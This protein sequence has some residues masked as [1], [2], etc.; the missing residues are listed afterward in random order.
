MARVPRGHFERSTRPVSSAIGSL[1]D[2]ALRGD[3]L[4]PRRR[5]KGQ[6]P[7]AERVSHLHADGELD[8][9]LDEGVDEGVAGPR[10][11]GAH[12]HGDPVFGIGAEGLDGQLGQ[13]EIEHR[14][15][16]RRAVRMGVARPQHH[17]EGLAGGVAKAGHRMEPKAVLVRRSG[18]VLLRVR[19]QEGG[20][21]VQDER[22][23]LAERAQAG[24]PGT[25][26]CLGSSGPDGSE[27][28]AV[29]RVDDPA[30]RRCRRHGTEERGLIPQHRK[31]R[32]A[33]A[34]V[35]QRERHVEEDSARIV[36]P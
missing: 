18:A 26:A 29:D 10:G 9:A 15:V 21:D 32:E 33:I 14:D 17:G 28:I 20:V 11:V 3:G 7:Q 34:T 6:D 25:S 5:G 4:G 22:S 2:L 24:L 31:V 30:R 1:A 13:G 27:A 23:M 8:P 36:A 16:I 12:Q 19:V 35:G